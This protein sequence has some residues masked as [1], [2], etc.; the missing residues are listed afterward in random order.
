VPGRAPIFQAAFTYQ[1]A[2]PPTV[3]PLQ[4]GEASFQLLDMVQQEGEYE[5]NCEIYEENDSFRV[6]FKF[7]PDLYD[8][9]EVRARLS[10]MCEILSE[11]SGQEWVKR[12]PSSGAEGL[13]T[14]AD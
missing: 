6:V 1:S 13:A 11:Q 10:R 3:R 2:L 8:Q 12:R 4:A 14:R 5:F 7:N 9:D